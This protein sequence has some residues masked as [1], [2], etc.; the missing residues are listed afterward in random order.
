MTTALRTW[1]GRKATVTVT[2][3]DGST[4]TA[5]GARAERAAAVVVSRDSAA[6]P[7]RL[8]L[9]SDPMAAATEAAR[10]RTATSMVHAG[11]RFD[12]DPSE[13]AEAILVVDA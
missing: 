9:R 10:K 8:A 3:P 7:Y 13:Y 1:N 2:L 4:L 12:I 6:T 5:G 11:H